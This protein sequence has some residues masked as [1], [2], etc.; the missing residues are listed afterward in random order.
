MP[1]MTALCSVSDL[2]F[3]GGT[4]KSERSHCFQS[5]ACIFFLGLIRRSSFTAMYVSVYIYVRVHIYIYIYIYIHTNI[6]IYRSQ[7]DLE[8]I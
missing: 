4:E 1:S 2:N 6:Y 3:S 8:S 5:S 7:P